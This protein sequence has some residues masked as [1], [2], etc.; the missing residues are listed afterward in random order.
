[1]GGGEQGR[2]SSW[3]GGQRLKLRTRLRLGTP[4]ALGL[5]GPLVTC[6]YKEKTSHLS[7]EEGRCVPRASPQCP[8]GCPPTRHRAGQVGVRAVISQAYWGVKG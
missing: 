7:L 8:P 4:W 5:K 1:M 6:G 2:G 3:G